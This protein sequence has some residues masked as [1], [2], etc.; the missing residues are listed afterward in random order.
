MLASQEGICSVELVR[1]MYRCFSGICS[2][3]NQSKCDGNRFLWNVHINVAE[4]TA[5]KQEVK[6]SQ[7]LQG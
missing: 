1:Y 6:F 5:P 3:H 4:H 2:L 7:G